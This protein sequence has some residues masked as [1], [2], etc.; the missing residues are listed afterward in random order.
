[1]RTRRRRL[2]FLIAA[3]ALFTP[4]TVAS[5]ATAASCTSLACNVVQCQLACALQNKV[6]V[7]SNGVCVC[8]GL[9][10]RS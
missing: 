5:S 3:V 7:C 4:T 1:M 8:L 6:G 2:T 9:T 10:S